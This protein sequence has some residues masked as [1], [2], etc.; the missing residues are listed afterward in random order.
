MI[1]DRGVQF[2]DCSATTWG[3]GAIDAYS[4]TIFSIG[5][6]SS[7]P[8]SFNGCNT[9]ASDNGGGAIQIYADE[10]GEEEY[11]FNYVNFTGCSAVMGGGLYISDVES[12]ELDNTNF[13]FCEAEQGAGVY[14]VGTS[15]MHYSNHLL[16]LI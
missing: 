10:I 16:L 12:I 6:T 15:F 5:G 13:E 11:G 1:I 14:S 4:P 7:L 3:G 8:V 9:N 2:N